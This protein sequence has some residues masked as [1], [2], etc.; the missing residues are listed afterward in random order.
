MQPFF[1]CVLLI[2]GLIVET[3]LGFNLCRRSLQNQRS[4]LSSTAPST[5]EEDT[6]VSIAMAKSSL[7]TKISQSDRGQ[8]NNQPL[9]KEIENLVTLLQQLAP[10][11]LRVSTRLLVGEWTLIYAT[12]DITRS[13][14]FFMAFKKA[15]SDAPDVTDSV[16]KITDMDFF[17]LKTIGAATQD[18]DGFAFVS[19]VRLNIN[20]VGSSVMST[21]STWRVDERE[22]D[23]LELSVE[24]TKV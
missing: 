9:K 1:V 6:E 19:K 5:L 18:I 16:Y 11:D 17:G 20:P 22:R 3:P 14:P 21:T 13:S 24:N 2:I 10:T 4:A 12:D 7:L 23:M 8:A 15:F